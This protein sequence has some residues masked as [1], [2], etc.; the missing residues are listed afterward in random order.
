[1]A[2][3][4]FSF[5]RL[6]F[7]EKKWPGMNAFFYLCVPGKL[8]NMSDSTDFSIYG[9]A[10]LLQVYDMPTAVVFYRDVIGFS[11]TAQSEPDRGDDC[12]WVLMKLQDVE[13]MLNTQYEKD[14]R[15]PAPDPVRTKWHHDTTLYFGCPDI[16]ALYLSFLSKGATVNS[17]II[18]QYNFRAIYLT[19]PD[20]YQLCLHWPVEEE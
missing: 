15:P 9:T 18:T 20:G 4:S 6:N 1:M 13:L 7:Q 2:L 14:K 12:N 3:F 5:L 17:P 11:V 16:R 19:D 10:P 8:N